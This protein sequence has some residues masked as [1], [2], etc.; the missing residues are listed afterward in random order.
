M[1][2]EVECYHCQEI[3]PE[4]YAIYFPFG[5][6]NDPFRPVCPNCANFAFGEQS[7]L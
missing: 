1:K 3:F 5:E 6:G 2:K 4:E 7:E